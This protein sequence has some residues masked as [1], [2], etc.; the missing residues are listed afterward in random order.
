M[1]RLVKLCSVLMAIFCVSEVV[2]LATSRLTSSDP[3]ASF[4]EILA[5]QPVSIADLPCDLH[6][7]QGNAPPISDASVSYCALY[8]VRGTFAS[9]SAYAYENRF[10][11]TSL[12]V[13]QD[14]YAGNL[15]LR[16]GRPDVIVKDNR[17]FYVRWN[18]PG[19][20]A[21]IYPRGTVT[22]FHYWLP[23]ASLTIGML[24]NPAGIP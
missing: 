2:V 6:P 3:F 19:L 16:W 14:L 13:A 9:I 23:I 5:G 24:S 1:W 22:H 7:I 12:R 17:S 20:Y 18:G 11:K 10:V 15:V 21:L 8:P 4:E